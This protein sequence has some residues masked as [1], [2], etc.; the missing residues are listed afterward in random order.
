MALSCSDGQ[1]G[2]VPALL[3]LLLAVS[4]AVTLAQGRVVTALNRW[5]LR[6]VLELAQ[7]ACREFLHCSLRPMVST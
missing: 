5:R 2:I 4:W 6:R 3:A 7:G 1:A